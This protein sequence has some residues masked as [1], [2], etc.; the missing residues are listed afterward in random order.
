MRPGMASRV[1]RIKN[2][3]HPNQAA[4]NP[5]VDPAK[6]RGIPMKL[7]SKAYCVAVNRLFVRLAINA[8]NAVCPSP[9]EM[10]SKAMTAVRVGR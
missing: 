7:V 5:V 10:V 1:Q 3:S 6:T 2:P 8:T 9:L 4:R